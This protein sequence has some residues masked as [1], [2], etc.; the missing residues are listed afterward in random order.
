MKIAVVTLLVA[1]TSSIAWAA[2]T[3]STV[4]GDWMSPNQSVIRIYPCSGAV[5][6]KIVK[7]SASTPEREDNNNPKADLRSRK[8]C[9]LDIGTGFKQTDPAHLQDGHLYDPKNGRTYQGTIVAEG[10]QLNLRGFIGI[11]LLG[12]TEVW[13]RVAPADPKSC[14][15]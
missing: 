4:M 5:C 6:A 15:V 1:A 12:R 7:L 9:G 11:S 14:G 2:G 10:D 13:H 8:L 3:S